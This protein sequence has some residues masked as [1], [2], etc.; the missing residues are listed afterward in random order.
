M[1]LRSMHEPSLTNVRQYDKWKS[2][3]TTK[4]SLLGVIYGWLS[5]SLRAL[6]FKISLT[7]NPFHLTHWRTKN[8]HRSNTVIA[9]N[10][11]KKRICHTLYSQLTPAEWVV[12]TMLLYRA[13]QPHQSKHPYMYQHSQLNGHIH[14]LKWKALP[15]QT[16]PSRFHS[17]H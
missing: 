9:T 4:R 14:P 1:H 8:N 17:C 6:Y 7:W 3:Q 11:K 16:L 2:T 5:T 10:E 12:A 13:P 15:S